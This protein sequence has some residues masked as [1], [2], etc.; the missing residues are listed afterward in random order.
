MFQKKNLSLKKWV[1]K[2]YLWHI[3][4]SHEL[5][6]RDEFIFSSR[7]SHF[8][9]ESSGILSLISKE[10]LKLPSQPILET[11]VFQKHLHF[12]CLTA[13]NSSKRPFQLLRKG[14]PIYCQMKIHGGPSSL[15][16]CYDCTHVG[17]YSNSMSYSSKL[18]ELWWD[19]ISCL[20][21]QLSK[22]V[23]SLQHTKSF[24]FLKA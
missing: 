22:I 9:L 1:N 20:Y 16:V 10:R 4:P 13:T 8:R 6:L 19:V 15:T 12:K 3:C 2:C 18:S 21:W 24:I 5:M 23:A 17:H 7:P 11:L 14:N